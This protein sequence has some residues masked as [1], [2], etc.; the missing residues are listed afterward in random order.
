MKHTVIHLSILAAMATVSYNPAYAHSETDHINKDGI[1]AVEFIGMDAPAT[2]E[3]RA[4]VY[5]AAR[6]KIS[7]KNGHSVIKPL[8]YKQLFATTDNINGKLAGGL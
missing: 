2:A 1:V 6:V 4:S 8:E 5:S 7:Y 3:Q